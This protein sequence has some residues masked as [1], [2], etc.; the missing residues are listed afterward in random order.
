[1]LQPPIPGLTYRQAA[2]GADT[3]AVR[4]GCYQSTVSG[5]ERRRSALSFQASN[6]FAAL[7]H[8]LIVEPGELQVMQYTM[9]YTMSFT[10]LDKDYCTGPKMSCRITLQGQQSR[11][12]WYSRTNFCDRNKL[13]CGVFETCTVYLLH[14]LSVM[15]RPSSYLTCMQP[16][17][18]ELQAPVRVHVLTVVGLAGPTCN[19][20]RRPCTITDSVV[21]SSGSKKNGNYIH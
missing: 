5:Q 8:S 10:A 4:H 16:R 17:Q 21:E 14:V 6:A 11:Y 15:R 9:P 3:H 18:H 1:M 7:N 2:R 12:T 20:F 13:F 19:T